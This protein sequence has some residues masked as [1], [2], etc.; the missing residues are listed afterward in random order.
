MMSALARLYPTTSTLRPSRRSL[1][2]IL[3]SAPTPE[4]SQKCA[5]ETSISTLSVWPSVWN[6]RV[7]RSTEAKKI[8]PVTRY[9]AVRP[10]GDTS[11]STANIRRTLPAKNTPDNNTPAKT[12]NDRSCVATT[13]ITV[14]SMTIDDVSG[15]RR[16]LG[17]EF[18]LN[19]PID[20]MIITATSARSEEH[21]SE[22][23]SLMRISYA[24]FCLKKKKNTAHQNK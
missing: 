19:V 4:I 2:T 11:R 18:Q 24:V 21:T 23:Q 15:W 6:A 22:L 13:T 17:I 1:A 8:C 3:S 14:V 10:S 7:K 5:A 16:K 9:V 12:P 20:T